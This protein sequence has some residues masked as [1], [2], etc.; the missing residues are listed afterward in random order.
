MTAR[1]PAAIRTVRHRRAGALALAAGLIASVAACPGNGRPS[2]SRDEFVDAYIQLVR[3]RIDARGDSA[4]YAAKRDQVFRQT[5]ATPEEMR[6]FIRAGRRDPAALRGAWQAIAAKLDTL[7]G[8]VTAAA[9]PELR[10]AFESPPP[11]HPE[12]DSLR[13][14]S[15]APPGVGRG[16]ER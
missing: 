12:P 15:P 14:P 2:L 8:G 10:R 16:R 3:A 1:R 4:A 6:A 11:V 13:R 5:A 7:Y 9:P